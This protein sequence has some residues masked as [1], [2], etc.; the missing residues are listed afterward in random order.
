MKCYTVDGSGL[1]SLQLAERPAPAVGPGDVVVDVHA[2]SLNYRDLLVADGRY[3]G[4]QDP[5]IIA[6]S[7][8]AGVVQAVGSEVTSLA[9]GDRVFNSPFRNWPAGT[10]R[11]EW[12]R[13]FVGGQGIDGVLAEEVAYPAD[14]LVPIPAHLDFGE[15]STLTV[16]GLTAWAAIVTHGKATAGDWVLLHGT[17][18]VSIFAAQIAKLLGARVILSTASE[19]K[20]AMVRDRFGVDRTINYRDDDWPRQVRK[21]TGGNGVDVVV[22]VAGGKSLQRSIDACAFGA[23]IGLIGVLSGN[24]A[25]IDV[26]K[27]LMRQVTIRGI[28]MESTQEL[29]AF[30]RAVEAGD[31]HPRIDRRFSF[32]QAREAYDYLGSRQHVGKIVIDVR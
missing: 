12:S 2:V 29:Q 18:G 16:A 31:L 5:P 14:A 25:L 26:F 11:R 6:T 4:P 32:D 30:A 22:E 1:D 15:A 21:L 3:G 19:E 9:P 23:R 13:T 8:M 27:T 24:E 10:L 28:Y 7:D 17:G 20:A